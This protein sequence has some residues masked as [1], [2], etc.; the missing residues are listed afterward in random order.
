MKGAVFLG[1]SMRVDEARSIL[2]NADYFPPAARGDV[3]SAAKKGY[4]AI[5]L[6]DGVFY[7][8]A[9]VAP[10]EILN[11]LEGGIVV[12]GGSSMGALRAS[13]LDIYGMVGVGRIYRW[14]KDGTINSDDEVALVFHPSTFKALSEP[15]V[16]I[17][18]T[19]G[20]LCS[21]G[22]VT[23]DEKEVLIQAAQQTP[24]QLRNYIRIVQVALNLGLEKARGAGLLQ[25]MEDNRVDQK[26]EDA[27]EVL[28]KLRDVL[29]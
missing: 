25:L 14:Y 6:V 17:R 4:G 12:V 8:R 16:N 20:R 9:A 19:L 18:A 7:Q 5:G 27:R 23:T 13:E 28:M 2:P 29:R 15:L 24:F 26:E 21:K 22:L 3:S 1:P 10:R 11:A